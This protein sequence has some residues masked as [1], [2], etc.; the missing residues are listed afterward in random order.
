[1]GARM[2]LLD[3]VSSE[4]RPIALAVV[5]V[6]VKGRGRVRSFRGDEAWS[7]LLQWVWERHLTWADFESVEHVRAWV[8]SWMR[9][10]CHG[11]WCNE[12][13][14]DRR[15]H[16]GAAGLAVRNGRA[17][18]AAEEADRV[19]CGVSVV[20][21]VMPRHRREVLLWRH[22]QGL[23]LSECA[24]LLGVGRSCVSYHLV[25]AE[26]EFRGRIEGTWKTQRR[27]SFMVF[28][29]RRSSGRVG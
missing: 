19:P 12:L 11:L 10:R 16:V 17:V 6:S 27:S 26:R 22:A 13:A 5:A 8:V 3:Y 23:T 28:D 29:G 15:L 9:R 20:L 24:G 21:A 4:C 1:M 25:Q 18:D 2:T 14:R 7:Q